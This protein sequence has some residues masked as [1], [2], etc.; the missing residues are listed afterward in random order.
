MNKQVTE[1]AKQY[2]AASAKHL[3]S[4]VDLRVATRNYNIVVIRYADMITS[5]DTTD[6]A[7]IEA[8]LSESA[9]LKLN[10]SANLAKTKDA[11]VTTAFM[12]I[13]VHKKYANG[14]N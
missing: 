10:A 11:L 6:Y 8:E 9:D 1:A 3:S 7:I 13:R 2:T 14:G 12:L 5:E 4:K